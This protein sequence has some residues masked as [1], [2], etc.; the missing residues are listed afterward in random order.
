[1]VELAGYCTL[2]AGNIVMN[3]ATLINEV[4]IK[5]LTVA[6]LQSLIRRLDEEPADKL[7]SET[8]EFKSFC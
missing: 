7:E 3:N 1:M 6:G 2:I 8:L 5:M 4:I